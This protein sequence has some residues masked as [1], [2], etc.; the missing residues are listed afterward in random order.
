MSISPSVGSLLLF[1]RRYTQTNL[2]VHGVSISQLLFSVDKWFTI[3]HGMKMLLLGAIIM[4]P[5]EWLTSYLLQAELRMDADAKRQRLRAA[6][7]QISEGDRSAQPFA[8][9]SASWRRLLTCVYGGSLHALLCCVVR[10]P[11]QSMSHQ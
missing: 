3:T 11:E 8:A 4:K 9:V 10:F 1:G 7:P 2:R 6:M 5:Q